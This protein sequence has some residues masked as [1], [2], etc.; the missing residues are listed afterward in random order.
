MI[1]SRPWPRVAPPVVIVAIFGAMAAGL[2]ATLAGPIAIAAAGLVVLGYVAAK[3]P[4][5]LL[6]T[7]LLI[8]YY[9]GVAQ[10]YFPI[11][12]TVLLAAANAS[13]L[14]IGLLRREPLRVDVLGLVIW[15]MLSVMMAMGTLYAP[16]G[17]LAVDALLR[18]VALIA[19]P[20]LNVV[21]VTA[22]TRST[23]QMLLCI[24]AFGVAMTSVGLFAVGSGQRLE[25][26]GTNTIGVARATLMVPIIA[27]GM[28]GSSRRW[29]VRGAALT[30]SALAI[31]VAV[32]TGSRGP[33]V[34][35]SLVAVGLVFHRI[36]T[37]GL[38]GRVTL[39]LAAVAVL[40]G[41]ALLS[42]ELGATSFSRFDR[43]LAGLGGG[44]ARYLDSSSEARLFLY[45][46][47]LARFGDQPLIGWGTAAFESVHLTYPHNLLLQF[48]ADFG[49]V[50]VILVLVAIRIALTRSL[51]Q[52]R[53]WAILRAL[54]VYT[55][56]NAMV[57]GN[58]YEDR[59]AWVFVAMML[60]VPPAVSYRSRFVASARSWMGAR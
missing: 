5:V 27:V 12:I 59:T 28:F 22:A 58:A 9:K 35:L 17:A 11:D 60:L 23:R 31:L 41:V 4:G 6:A 56:L 57:S 30:L 29:S 8:P 49:T 1:A 3:Y 43:L 10:P 33:F 24:V 39:G 7:Y 34:A 51:T 40:G 55:L 37:G 44:D 21:R 26:F 32:A 18:W 50:G 48:A 46:Q 54:A 13:S 36:L 14:A 19:I 16:N 42:T 52:G 45:H 15:L 53:E 38:S 25:L 2:T 47:A 20:L